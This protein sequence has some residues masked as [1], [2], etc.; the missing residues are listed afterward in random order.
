MKAYKLQNITL[1]FNKVN[2]FVL[3]N[4]LQNKKKIKHLSMQFDA[5]GR[6]F[7][8]EELNMENMASDSFFGDRSIFSSIR[9]NFIKSVGKIK[10]G[11]KNEFTDFTNGDFILETHLKEI[12]F[13]YLKNEMKDKKILDVETKQEVSI[14]VV[15]DFLLR[16][17][18]SVSK[19]RIEDGSL[20]IKNSRKISI[21]GKNEEIFQSKG[22]IFLGKNDLYFPNGNYVSIKDLEVCLN[23]H[24]KFQ[25]EIE[26]LNEK[27]QDKLFK[28][29]ENKLEH[30]RIQNYSY[31]GNYVIEKKDFHFHSFDI[32]WSNKYRS[33]L[34]N[35]SCNH[36][37]IWNTKKKAKKVYN[38]A[39]IVIAG[40]MSTFLGFRLE[41]PRTN[42]IEKNFEETHLEYELQAYHEQE[43]YE[44]KDDVVRRL[45]S[46]YEV[47]DIVS[48]NHDIRVYESSDY[49]YVCNAKSGILPSNSS[50]EI[51]KISILEN[52]E[53]VSIFEEEGMNVY[54]AV[55]SLENNENVD[56]VF[57]FKEFG[58]LDVKDLFMTSDLE[59]K[60]I[61][62]EVVM[63]DKYIG[64]ERN[65]VNDITFKTEDGLVHLNV[66]NSDGDLVSP[67]ST[68]KDQ[69][70]N[71]YTVKKLQE[72]K[73]KYSQI[74]EEKKVGKIEWNMHH[75]S[76][77]YAYF[78]LLSGL[79]GAVLLNRKE[80]KLKNKLK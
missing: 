19:L 16:S 36:E 51:D 42:M 72:F 30:K 3:T 17:I 4:E 24:Y 45:L 2:K 13:E 47:G 73:E 14:E 74:Y 75:I 32:K 8:K 46:Q 27:E 59:P 56:S 29:K 44:A 20:K 54:K 6:A 53:I 9:G 78:T 23:Q 38:L 80:E 48:L 37:V 7:V 33:F 41:K 52:G 79:L 71:I 28:E 40:I 49:K 67:L 31:S 35:T 34:N 39:P 11:K 69:Y 77:K 25:E 64:I 26:I 10:M 63:K 61:G 12:L 57:H 70:G 55:N 5:L 60:I 43:I 68:L 22:L 62:K 1:L 58:W 66:L 15:L 50:Y 21:K 76:L 65:F 18:H